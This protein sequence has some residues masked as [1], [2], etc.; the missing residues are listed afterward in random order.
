MPADDDHDPDDHCV[1]PLNVPL[2]EVF[3]VIVILNN[4]LLQHGKMYQ[5]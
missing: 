3:Q 1:L 2:K 4:Y 5:M